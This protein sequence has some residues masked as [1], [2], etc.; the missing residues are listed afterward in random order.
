MFLLFVLLCEFIIYPMEQLCDKI[1]N[2]RQFGCLRLI[3]Y[4]LS[5]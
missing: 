5:P 3:E 4:G 1:Y 2:G